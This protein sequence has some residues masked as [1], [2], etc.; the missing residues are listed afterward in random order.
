MKNTI[1]DKF[2][3]E[4]DELKFQMNHRKLYNFHT[5]LIRFLAKIGLAVNKWLPFILAY[6]MVFNSSIY[7]KNKPFRR[8]MVSKPAY[9]QSIDTSKGVHRKDI[10]SEHKETM[11]EY[12]TAW[13]MNNMGL[14]QRT[15]TSYKTNDKIDLNNLD[16]VL[17]MT[18]EEI[19][20]ALKIIDTKVITKRELTDSDKI[21][22][23][24][25]LII[26]QYAKS[27]DEKVLRLE[28]NFENMC[29]TALFI[30]IVY[31]CTGLF[32]GIKK[33]LIKNI[34]DDKL[35]AVIVA[36]K[37]ISV[38][39]YR[40]MRKILEIKQANLTLVQEKETNLKENVRKIKRR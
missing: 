2:T 19:D 29:Q 16:E 9:I 23:D 6:T 3:N 35:N 31:M 39:D 40:R 30:S 14:Y 28:T 37:Y 15:T 10:C 24:G 22:D 38:D 36:H 32:I 17:D 18:K 7:K 1:V 4:I 5:F 8:D 12:S 25:V 34:I 21:Y 11:F 20:E 27:A 13:S 33:I 26:T